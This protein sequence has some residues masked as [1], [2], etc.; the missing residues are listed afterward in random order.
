M[1]PFGLSATNRIV[2]AELIAKSAPTP[3]SAGLRARRWPST[4]SAERAEG[5]GERAASASRCV[6]LGARVAVPGQPE[7]GRDAGGAR[8]RQRHADQHQA[9]QHQV[10]P[11]HR[12]E[13]RHAE[14]AEDRVAEQEV[15]REELAHAAASMR[16]S[17]SETTTRAV[18][19][20][21]DRV[22]R[23]G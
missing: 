17:P 10:H 20:P 4:S 22:R 23:G 2:A 7:H 5:R 11:E 19:A 12:A 6:P 3:H 8:L 14:P 15:G 1:S 21:A 9:A 13:Q 16:T 18:G